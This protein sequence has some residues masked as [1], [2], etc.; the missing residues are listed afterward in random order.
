MNGKLNVITVHTGPLAVNTYVAW[1]EGSNEC[2]VV[3]PAACSPVLAE[4]EKLGLTVKAI[5]LTHGHFDHILGVAGLKERTGARVYISPADAPCLKD[6]KQSLAS[7]VGLKQEPV[8]PDVKLRDGGVFTEAGIE[9]TVLFTPGHTKGSVCFIVESDRAIF[10]GDTLFHMSYGRTDLRG[11]SSN[12]L[13]DS[14]VFKLFALK[15]DYRVLPGHEYET[16]LQ[17]ERENNPCVTMGI[18]E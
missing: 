3:D 11:G 17:F 13:F 6:G 4:T 7:M 10:S 15:G 8:V 18:C 2:V 5:L 1:N 9:F 14:I 16:T 12:D